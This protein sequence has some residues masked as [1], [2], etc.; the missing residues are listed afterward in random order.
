MPVNYCLV[1]LFANNLAFHANTQTRAHSFTDDEWIVYDAENQTIPLDTT[2]HD[3]KKSLRLKQNEIALLRDS[4]Y[5]DFRLEV[6]MMGAG[7]AGIGFHSEDLFNYEFI[8]AKY[9][10]HPINAVAARTV[11]TSESAVRRQ[12]LFDYTH[13]LIIV[14]N[15]EVLFYGKEMDDYGYVHDGEETIALPLKE[16]EN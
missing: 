10:S 15:S 5:D 8:L 3:G 1:I 6:D 4:D 11:L 14:L 7:M 2:I 13:N 16:G 12:L 9:V